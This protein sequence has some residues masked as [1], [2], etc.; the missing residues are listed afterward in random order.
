MRYRKTHILLIIAAFLIGNYGVV[1]AQMKMEW[2][3]NGKVVTPFGLKGE[4]EAG[5]HRGIDILGEPGRPVISPADGL[6]TF[7]RKNTLPSSGGGM[8]LTIEHENDIST[9]Y[10][11]IDNV[12]VQKG[13]KVKAGQKIATIHSSGD[14]AS[15]SLPHLHFGVYATSKKTSGISRYLDPEAYLPGSDS[16]ADTKAGQLENSSLGEAKPAEN[17]AAEPATAIASEAEHANI[18]QPVKAK[19]L[20]GIK[21][22]IRKIQNI[23]GFRPASNKGQASI[24]I[25]GKASQIS[26][27]NNTRSASSTL[28]A[29]NSRLQVFAKEKKPVIKLSKNHIAVGTRTSN[30]LSELSL[31]S[32]SGKSKSSMR[33]AL[34]NKQMAVYAGSRAQAEGVESN[35]YEFGKWVV[36]QILLASSIY[37][38]AKWTPRFAVR[39]AH[40]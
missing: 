5:S 3:V 40:A 39:F 32:G 20:N 1:S 6:V 11:G 25:K 24:P 19:Q 15:Y 13:Q 38:M 10:S 22:P 9:T 31:Q 2:P 16:I 8:L 34:V 23:K 30:G 14:A 29:K 18:A 35:R 21:R 37:S 12:E 7:V 28:R 26:S 17:I 4:Y 33:Q 27:K 36:L